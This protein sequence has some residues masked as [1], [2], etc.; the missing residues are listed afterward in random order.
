MDNSIRRS[1]MDPSSRRRDINKD[2]QKA[3]KLLNQPDLTTEQRIELAKKMVNEML[4]TI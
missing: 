2:V 3:A 4:K 1:E